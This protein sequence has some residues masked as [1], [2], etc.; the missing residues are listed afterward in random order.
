M[1]IF[2]IKK[3]WKCNFNEK[4][5]IAKKWI[6]K[7]FGYELYGIEQIIKEMNMF[8]DKKEYDEKL[9]KL[10]VVF[11]NIVVSMKKQVAMMT[12]IYGMET[13]LLYILQL[14]PTY[15]WI[16][17][18][19][20]AYDEK[21]GEYEV[22]KWANLIGE[23]WKLDFNQF[24]KLI[25][26]IKGKT[27]VDIIFEKITNENTFIEKK[28]LQNLYDIKLVIMSCY[29]KRM[30]A[31]KKKQE[32]HQKKYDKLRQTLDIKTR[33]KCSMIR[34]AMKENIDPGIDREQWHGISVA[35]LAELLKNWKKGERNE[36]FI[37]LFLIEKEMTNWITNKDYVDIS[38]EDELWQDDKIKDIKIKEKM[39]M[40]KEM[41]MD[42][43]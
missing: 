42:I 29:R 33:W 1:I 38:M 10:K 40:K 41:D 14:H 8:E 9:V 22:E 12:E 16:Y 36:I 27:D 37:N 30:F 13:E 6:N 26:F 18:L 31:S 21:I 2:K 7:K 28:L 11:D 17:R 24:E 5:K 15:E 19:R 35:E 34:K 3:I 23:I 20:Y 4:I 39:S 43:N 25:K 32:T